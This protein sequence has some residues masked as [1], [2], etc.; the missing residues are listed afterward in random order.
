MNERQNW[1]YRTLPAELANTALWR[2][3]DVT[4]LSEPERER[5]ERLQRAI[6]A[7][8]KTGHLCATS[9]EAGISDG[10]IIRLLNRCV[11]A[12]QDGNLV[13]WPALIS[14]HRVG[15]YVRAMDLPSGRAGCA[16][17][18]AGSFKIFLREHPD[19]KHTIDTLAL[20]RKEKG[21]VH[22]A[23]ISVKNLHEIFK[24][25]CLQVGITHEEYPLNSKSCAKRSL[26]RYMKQLEFE[27]A[28]ESV[29]ARY[30]A[31]A[32]KRL[33]VGTGFSPHLLSFAPFDLVGLD[34][35][36]TDC[37]GIIRIN[38]PEG[39]QRVPIQR[40]WIITQVSIMCPS[41]MTNTTGWQMVNISEIRR[42]QMKKNQ[43]TIVVYVAEDG[44]E[45]ADSREKLNLKRS[46]SHE[47]ILEVSV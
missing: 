22:E 23:R 46:V 4:A 11:T 30:G 29:A 45:L 14:G 5:F 41:W 21:V 27:N 43:A 38:G 42:V 28:G 36:K 9:N 13:G 34:A 10:E 33:S 47:S 6:Q 1:T 20:K 7:Y 40:I 12:A 17:G 16:C 44:R 3:V 37:I 32:S 25:L 31:E 15:G 19:I 35:H 26:G 8:V 18:F 2:K 24:K 39:P